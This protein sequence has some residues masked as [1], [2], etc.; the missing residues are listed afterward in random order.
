MSPREQ[1]RRLRSKTN[2]HVDAC[3]ERGARVQTHDLIDEIMKKYPDDVEAQK[4]MMIRETLG[5]WIRR[6]FKR[7]QSS[8]KPQ[9]SLPMDLQ[10]ITLPRS[11]VVPAGLAGKTKAA[12]KE[13]AEKIEGMVWSPVEAVTFA[14]LESYIVAQSASIAG[15]R[16]R[17]DPMMRLYERVRPIMEKRRRFEIVGVVTAELVARGAAENASPRRRRKTA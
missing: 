5:T 3:M 17:L 15:R 1:K 2:D 13:A 12:R 4:I 9:L 16:D 10:N 6:A 14:E 7:R 11:I 8:K